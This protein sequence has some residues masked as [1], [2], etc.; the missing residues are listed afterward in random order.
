MNVVY[1]SGAI[2]ATINGKDTRGLSGCPQHCARD[3]L[4]QHPRL[5]I[6][7]PLDWVQQKPCPYYFSNH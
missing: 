2:V 5:P 1:E 7:M 3:C 4:R 6:L